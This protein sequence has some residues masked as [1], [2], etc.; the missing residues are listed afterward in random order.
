[1]QLAVFGAVV[2]RCGDYEQ[3]FSLAEAISVYGCNCNAAINPVMVEAEE[4]RGVRDRRTMGWGAGLQP[5][6]WEMGTV[7]GVGKGFWELQRVGVTARQPKLLGVQA[8][9]ANAISRA[10]REGGEARGGA[11]T[12]ADSIAVAVPRNPRKAIEAVRRSGGAMV[13]VSDDEIG[14]AMLRLGRSCALFAEPA[15]A[16]HGG[17]GCSRGAGDRGATRRRAWW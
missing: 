11:D 16:A 6:P 15:A 1:M 2:V 17:T 5:S 10:F 9:G 4:E 13:E 14:R 8:R 12:F 7:A 3:A